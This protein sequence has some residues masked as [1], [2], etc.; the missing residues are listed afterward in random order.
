MPAASPRAAAVVCHPH[1]EYGGDMDNTVVTTVAAVLVAAGVA[2]L[3]F[4]FG[5]VGRSEGA[6]GGGPA[7]VTDVRAAIDSIRAELPTVPIIVVGYSFGSW[8]G[9]QAAAGAPDVTRMIAV[10]PPITFFDWTFA[11]TLRV[12]LAVVVGDRDQFC[13]LARLEKLTIPTEKAIIQGAD[14]FFAGHTAAVAAA[15]RAF[16]P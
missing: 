2:A 7:E 9:A 1:P 15:V 12:P 4:N 13:P 6:Y 14:H 11:T 16:I 10:A 8:V 5:G 3:R